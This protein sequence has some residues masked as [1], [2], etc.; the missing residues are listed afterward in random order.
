MTRFQGRR[1]A[2]RRPVPA[3]VGLS[4]IDGGLPSPLEAFVANHTAAVEAQIASVGEHAD[5]VWHAAALDIIR[6][7]HAGDTFM[8]EHVV[9]LLA[10]RGITTADNRAAG[11]VIREAR[12]LGL[13]ESA[14]VGAAKSSHGSAKVRW[15]RCAS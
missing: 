5:P 12:K 3:T 11:Q 9:S 10:V 14:G 4:A 15:R 7:T 1:E 8:A 13:I 2:R 6:D